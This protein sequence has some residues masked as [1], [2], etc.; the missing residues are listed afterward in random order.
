MMISSPN[1]KSQPRS[2]AFGELEELQANH[3]KP[4]VVLIMTNW[5]KYCHAMKNSMLKN[6]EITDVLSKEYYLI[7]MNAE[8]V[9]DIVY[10]GKKYKFKPTGSKTG[11]HELA[12]QL[13]TING[14]V[15]YPALCFL[16]A[17]NEIIYQYDGYLNSKALLALLNHLAVK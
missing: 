6:K 14:R 13:A 3:P 15:S 12:E 10:R 8:D 9:R 4:V 5:C 16:N 2:I 7:F 11:V 1:V 17:D